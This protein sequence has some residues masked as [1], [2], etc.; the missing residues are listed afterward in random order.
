MK[1]IIS[2][3]PQSGQQ[4]LFSL[5]CGIPM[6]TIVLRP[7]ETQQGVCEIRDFRL[8]KLSEIYQPKK[9][10]YAKIEYLLLPDFVTQG[11]TKNIIF[12]ELKNADEICWVCREETAEEDIPNFISELIIADLSLAEKRIENLDKE[13]KKKFLDTKEKEKNIMELSKKHL[14]SGKPLSELKL[15][16]EQAKL[17]KN[18]QFFTL[19]PIVIIVNVSENQLKQT[20][21]INK[22]KTEFNYPCIQL[23]I[24]LEQEI[25]SL[26]KTERAEFMKEMGIDEPALDKMNRITFEGLG[27]ISFFTVGK[28]EV[29]SWPIRKSILAPEAG[30][31]IHSDIEKG[32]V[33]AE[34]MKYIDF[35]EA[36]S[37]SKVKELGKFYLKGKDYTVEDGDI[38]NFR[39]NV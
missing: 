21:I 35:I 16:E 6:D 24:E 18:F 34:L 26:D 10:V 14:E 3:L 20:E 32:F 2:G 9:T 27:Y 1:V 15:N 17:L 12:N 30:S 28:D 36:G 25:S 33:R 23:S 39:F 8:T 31:T 13:Q 37:E 38:L 19:K 5:L 7:M 11:L 29:R 22:I 4:Q